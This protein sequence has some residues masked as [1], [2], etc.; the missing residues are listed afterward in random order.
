MT[1]KGFHKILCG[2]SQGLRAS[3]IKAILM[4]GGALPVY[5]VERMTFDLDFLLDE[6]A[7]TQFS[8]VL[9]NSG[10][11]QVLKTAQFSKFRHPNAD[12]LDIDAVFV[13]S[14]TA[15]HAWDDGHDAQI[16]PATFRCVSLNAMFSTK[17]HALK[18][19]EGRRGTRDFD[20]I[21]CLIEANSVEVQSLGFKALCLKYGDESLYQRIQ[22]VFKR[23]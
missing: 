19:N 9:A 6:N 18:H 12:A 15:V 23:K 1:E 11:E 8:S 7:F 13:D 20:D 3:G 14:D 10:Y 5:G 21:L 22:K 2:I 16:G 4:G 17:L